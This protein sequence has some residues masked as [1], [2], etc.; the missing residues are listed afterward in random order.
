MSKFD[1]DIKQKGENF[2]LPPRPEVWKRVEAE[3]DKQNRGRMIGWWWLTPVIIIAW[4]FA[5]SFFQRKDQKAFY[6][7][8]ATYHPLSEKT[9]A[10]PNKV[11]SN[12][13][14]ATIV[15]P[16]P[17]EKASPE[18]SEA[19]TVSKPR[20]SNAN[21]SITKRT[22]RLPN[23]GSKVSKKGPGQ[24][25]VTANTKTIT[26]HG[27]AS[28]NNSAGPSSNQKKITANE[29]SGNPVLGSA[30]AQKEKQPAVSDKLSHPS[31]E[32][33]E[34]HTSQT[35]AVQDENPGSG[36][37]NAK[38]ATISSQ[39]P[40]QK[41]A[42]HSNAN[43]SVAIGNPASSPKTKKSKWRFSIGGGIA[44]NDSSVFK[45]RIKDTTDQSGG[46]SG[47][48]GLIPQM[49]NHKPGFSVAASLERVF[50]LSRRWQW[51]PGITLQYQEIKQV[52]G[53]LQP[54]PVDPS[55]PDW[56]Y[57]ASF[58][59]D[60]GK[61]LE[62]TGNN[63]RVALSSDISF[64]IFKNKPS[65]F[66]NAGVYGGYNIYNHF[67]LPDELQVWWIPASSNFYH[68]LFG[69]LSAGIEFRFK[70]GAGIGITGRHDLSKS[71]EELRDKK[72]YWQSVLVQFSIPL[73]NTR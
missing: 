62:H 44:I 61:T 67:L 56:D 58:Y 73:N 33:I 40:E 65:L 16:A 31:N 49:E 30:S 45:K 24:I 13:P 35:L 9:V 7:Q 12:K 41:A 64:S 43:E 27:P 63:F 2:S 3:L 37:V 70:N 20:A 23:S 6:N 69:G 18:P 14:A 5:F 4:G 11:D 51:K 52:T 26:N 32:H 55:P 68:D 57:S 36:K 48:G 54:Y 50:N 8:D 25:E 28:N 38:G 1:N 21:H 59:F 72:Y 29:K 42:S 60:P 34:S 17:G 22:V 15:I 53:D 39:Q 66:I 47:G 46:S 10:A 71:Y 19:V